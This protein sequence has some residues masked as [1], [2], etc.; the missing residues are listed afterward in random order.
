MANLTILN[1]NNYFLASAK[2]NYKLRL[3]KASDEYE[4]LL[5]GELTRRRHPRSSWSFQEQFKIIKIKITQVALMSK[6][7]EFLQKLDLY[8]PPKMT[9]KF[10][11]MS[12]IDQKLTINSVLN[13]LFESNPDLKLSA[14]FMEIFMWSYNDK[15]GILSHKNDSQ[16]D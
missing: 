16:Y 7:G 5:L 12:K 8:L 3:K 14:L 4:T 11:K 13:Q 10:E 1:K 9:D 2:V 6:N 15:Q